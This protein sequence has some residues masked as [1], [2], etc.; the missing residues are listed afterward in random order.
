MATRRRP[1]RFAY[2]PPPR[3]RSAAPPAPGHGT[4]RR[5]LVLDLA[6]AGAL[7]VSLPVYA[8]TQLHGDPDEA[9]GTSGSDTP[10]PGT[11]ATLP[12]AG[13]EPAHDGNS[14]D[15]NAT[16]GNTSGGNATGGSGDAGGSGGTS[17]A[18]S[19]K[20]PAPSGYFRFRNVGYGKCLAVTVNVVFD[21]CED[22]PV[23]NWT[24]KAG[25][26]G[27]YMLY[28]ESAGQCLT[29]SLDSCTWPT[30]VPRPARAGARVPAAPSCTWTAAG[31]STRSPAGQS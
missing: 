2:A 1:G 17:G 12:A 29:V 5:G 15:G 9:K 22:I 7:V 11:S 16:G 14:S 8:S 20:P 25:S 31:A 10:S 13:G 21:T 27:S 28:N 6:A 18:T 24:A 4:K 23:T 19:P 3:T 30:A 26:G